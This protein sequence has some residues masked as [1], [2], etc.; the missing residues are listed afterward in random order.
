MLTERRARAEASA[1]S[2]P[3]SQVAALA[4]LP[5]IIARQPGFDTVLAALVRGDSG[6]IDGAWGS[7]AAAAV[8]ALA[9]HCG[10]PLLV[11]LPRLSEVD[12]FTADLATFLEGDSEPLRPVV[13]PAWETPPTELSPADPVF[14]RR[15][16]VLEALD[17]VTPPRVLVAATAGL[18]QPV[19]P[20]ALRAGASRI[21]RVG[22]DLE[23]DGFMRW[24][25][26]RGFER[27]AAIERP[28]EFSLH[29]GI[30][31]LW[32]A[33]AADPLRIELFGDEI[34]SIR[35]FDVESQR[36]IETLTEAR[37]LI[38][39][40]SSGIADLTQRGSNAQTAFPNPQSAIDSLPADAA[41]V[42]VEPADIVAE[43]RHLWARLEEP[44]GLFSVEDMLAKIMQRPSVTVA[45]L[46]AD[47]F[48]ATCR[49]HVESVE[50][51]AGPKQQAL[52]E[53]AAA[54]GREERVLLACHNAGERDR[55]AELI[56]DFG[57]QTAESEAIPI[58][59]PAQQSPIR[60]R[61][62]LC[63][64]RI[65]KGFRLVA[66]RL[67]V[68]GD[69]E[70]FGREASVGRVVAAKSKK[71][72]DSR[73]ID[74]FLDLNE[75][76]LIVHLVNGI[77]RFRGMKVLAKGE[78]QEEHLE[79]EFAEGVRVYVPVSLIHL[80][81][82]Y[83]GATKAAP[84]L[85]KL[86]TLTWSN[87]KKRV[88]EAVKD[89]A[90]DMLRL[91]AAR[92]A[93][94]GIA[95]PPDS[96]W[97][98]EFEAAFPYTETPDQA[99]AITATKEDMLRP[100]PMDRLICGDV[101]YGK[102]EVAIRAAFKAVDAGRQ[103][104]ILVPTTVLA[105][106]H[107]RS[108]RERMAEFP[109][110][111][112]T[113][114]R[115]RTQKEQREIVKGLKSGAVDICIGTHRLVSPDVQFKDLG[116]L[117]IDEEQRFGVDVKDA[118]KRLRLEV[119]VLTLSATPIPRTLHM[120]LL[121]IRDIS[122][123][124]TPPR[125]RQAIETRVGRWEPPLIRHAIVREL[126]RGGQ[127]YF[128]HNRIHDIHRV[129]DKIQQI[130]PEVEIGIVHGRMSGD[131]LEATMTEFVRGRL[132]VL[133]A[134][135]IIESG[136]D[137]PNANTIFIHQADRYGLADLHQLRGRVG[138]DRHRAYCY[139]LLEEGKPLSGTALKR[140][141]AIEEF[142][143]LGAGFKIAMRDLEIRGAGNI[144]GNEQSGHI[145]TV[146]YELYCQLLENAV[147]A[148]KGEPPRQP[149]T[150]NVDLPVSAYLPN[151]YV[152]PGRQKIE[153]YRR[154]SNVRSFDELM[155]F[156]EELQDRFGT[157]PAVASRLLGIK[158]VQLLA[159]GWTIHELRLEDHFA[160]FGY[161]DAARIR[162][163][164]GRVGRDFRVVDG[165]S[166]YY[167]LSDPAATDEALLTA[168]RDVL[169]GS[170]SRRKAKN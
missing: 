38:V 80:V 111:I 161:N 23:P 164:A 123:L 55:L 124:T 162:T 116:L 22:D 85:S 157:P 163:L 150:V 30:L 21:V 24:L 63:L 97:Q 44:E 77:G 53:L 102:T 75:G 49:L 86:G 140:M 149:L 65:G 34:E 3:L 114:S 96:K 15:L 143:E 28:G 47:S 76:D 100:R 94:P 131:E 133:L 46:G 105:E 6:T 135:T 19:P 106:Q 104:A 92:E 42:L 151:S 43:G 56:A 115:F 5:G 147:L 66:E 144:L 109:V 1:E 170:V 89:M 148:L 169:T 71:R 81:Q 57:V 50:R 9:A 36:K 58:A 90:A 168:L 120:A 83:V 138:R 134:T 141:K 91:H 166:A 7:S 62:T 132:D 153:L 10:R 126:N 45:A 145:T 52:E 2:A 122:N 74:T 128:V 60:N 160:V 64:G 51:F 32:T 98:A 139:L 84:P 88:A 107:D 72:P 121:G 142:S 93:Q 73:A 155:Q 103:A 159:R 39:D 79:L 61:I 129:R 154:L 99:A 108:F 29:G 35:R 4:D 127:I 33:D 110:T 167:V 27:V 112:A 37:L 48:E 41:V 11:V 16:G 95:L 69:H 87:K 59:S 12:D 130:V 14:A 158:E 13:L 101:G 119:D 18:M 137:I 20:P 54:L 113:L 40:L 67:L 117:V 8:A 146:G 165:K 78:Q 68:L 70:L 25:I 136:L 118:L 31:D 152:P 156:R 26:D 125:D 82:K 17:S